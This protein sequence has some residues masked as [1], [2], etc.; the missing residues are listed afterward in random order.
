MQPIQVDH[1]VDSRL[2]FVFDDKVVS[3]NLAANATFADVARTLG[4]LANRR[5]GNPVAID[6][7][8]GCRESDVAGRALEPESCT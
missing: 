4:E 2:R 1:T 8:L 3:F 7:T 5:Y 6:V